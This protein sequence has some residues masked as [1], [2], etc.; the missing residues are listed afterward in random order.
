MSTTINP[1][2][3]RSLAWLVGSRGRNFG[4]I[5]KSMPFFEEFEYCN[6]LMND[7]C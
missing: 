3:S 1:T 5:G 7:D 4:T 2:K 6:G